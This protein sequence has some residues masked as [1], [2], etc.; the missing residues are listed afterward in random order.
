MRESASGKK[1]GVALIS[2]L[3]ILSLITLLLV[4]FTSVMMGDRQSTHS[5][6]G[7]MLSDEIARSAGDAV[8][9][10][11][12]AECRDTNN[13]A[14]VRYVTNG[15]VPASASYPVYRPLTGAATMPERMANLPAG[16]ELKLIVKGSLPGAPFYSTTAGTGTNLASSVST[17]SASLNGRTVSLL[18]WTKPQ[19]VAPSA[20][21]RFPVPSWVYVGRK[22]LIPPSA[23]DYSGKT[24]EDDAPVGRYAYLVYDVSG[25]L[26]VNVA[27]YPQAAQTAAQGKGLL[28]WVDLTMLT[29]T[30]AP[31]DVDALVAWRNAA[32]A[33]RYADY[34]TNEWATNGFRTIAKGDTAFLGRQELLRFTSQSSGKKWA[35]ALPYLT[36][37][38]REVNGPVWGPTTNAAAAPFDYVSHQ[39]GATTVSSP[40]T[41]TAYTGAS[42]TVTNYNCN[43]FILNPRVRVSYPN[44]FGVVR[45]VGEPLVSYR[46]P[47]EKLALLEATTDSTTWEKNR[48]E[49]QKW[50]G[51]DYVTTGTDPSS[52]LFRHWSYPTSNPRY[53]YNGVAN[54]I[55]TLDEV[56]SLKRDPNFF[57]LLQ[58]GILTGSLGKVGRGDTGVYANST[59]PDPDGVGA[60]QLMRIGANIVDQWDADDCPTTITFNGFDFYGIEDLPYLNKI[61]IKPWMASA[62]WRAATNNYPTAPNGL[63]TYLYFELWNPHLAPAVPVTE[64]PANFRLAPMAGDFYKPSFNY[65]SPATNVTATW[66]GTWDAGG[67]S[68]SQT[69]AVISS[70]ASGSGLIDFSAASSDDY[71]EPSLIP[72][73]TASQQLPSDRVWNSNPGTGPDRG[74]ALAG[75]TLPMV[76]F[77]SLNAV[78]SGFAT[79][80]PGPNWSFASALMVNYMIEYEWPKASGSYHPYA[81][82]AGPNSTGARSKWGWGYYMGLGGVPSTTASANTFA[83]VRADPRTPR[84]GM[85]GAS[86]YNTNTDLPRVAGNTLNPTTGTATMTNYNQLYNYLPWSKSGTSANPYRADLWAANTNGI[87]S[88]YA[89]PDTIMRG[90]D[91]SASFGSNNPY[92]P[93]DPSRPIVLNHP[94][95]SVGDLGYAYRDLPWKTLDLFSANS[96]DSALLDLFSVGE[97]SVP[98]GRVNPNS[99]PVPVLAALLAGGVA[100]SGGTTLSASAINALATS[101]RGVATNTPFVS[102]ADIVAQ[103]MGTN[104][105]SGLDNVSKLKA[106][107]E[108][109]LRAVAESA[110]TR[111]WNLFID[112]VA[113]SGR[114]PKGNTNP[115]AFRVEGERRYWLHVAIDRY[116]GEIV[117][118]QIEVVEE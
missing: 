34:V 56:A 67:T 41:S 46:F 50:F 81:T 13:A 30:L 15:A 2:T 8:V 3:A 111:T 107:R 23:V 72:G 80:W 100:D 113:Q 77:P 99:A 98:A 103:Y 39:Y 24:L 14:R 36:T 85:V 49:I 7:G 10:Q 62:D 104:A 106:Q 12:L 19:F 117:D 4:A 60:Y 96:G 69:S 89:D 116:T 11:L 58:A 16:E 115:T 20:T 55:L 21:N 95:T 22:G 29:N 88:A 47:L 76:Y 101:F 17:S 18:R 44:N 79:N 97:G 32:T 83:Y 71:R 53:G 42:T 57:E 27:G 26:D 109:V 74:V 102:R 82:V 38:S 45:K 75:V 37:F 35:A 33:S 61:L 5:Y 105:V 110:N 92:L 54:R 86:Y 52:G 112:I 93:K 9:G 73:A 28:P 43:V 90:G 48:D 1:G 118:R 59:A 6:V 66:Y 70:K 87:T 64:R 84:W 108:A 51:L 40:Y 65:N 68:S 94:F 91:A 31:A 25:L 114:Y 63:Q 78:A